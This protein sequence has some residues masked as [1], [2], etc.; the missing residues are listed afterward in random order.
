[1]TKT[2]ITRQTTSQ[3]CHPP[4]MNWNE[5]TGPG[6]YIFIEWGTLCRV[7]HDAVQEGRSPLVTMSGNNDSFPIACLSEDPYIPISK[8]R[9]IAA[10]SDF[11]VNF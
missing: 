2:K 8:A 1:M 6:T 5:I 9:Q 11:Y 10:D 7:P 3:I 4:T